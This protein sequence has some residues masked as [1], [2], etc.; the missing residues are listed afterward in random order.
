MSK[1]QWTLRKRQTKIVSPAKSGT[2]YGIGKRTRTRYPHASDRVSGKVQGNTKG[3][4]LKST[5]STCFHNFSKKW[6]FEF[7]LIIIDI[8]RFLKQGSGNIKLYT[9]YAGYSKRFGVVHHHQLSMIDL[10]EALV[11]VIYRKIR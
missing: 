5:A 6:A 2:P 7:T 4:K 10:Y 9:G 11:E 8:T 1:V 3:L